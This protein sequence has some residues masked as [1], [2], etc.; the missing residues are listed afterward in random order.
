MSFDFLFTDYDYVDYNDELLS[1]N[2][3]V[4]TVA[5]ESV[6]DAEWLSMTSLAP[7]GD[8]GGGQA[9]PRSTNISSRSSTASGLT[10]TDDTLPEPQLSAVHDTATQLSAEMQAVHD[11]ATQKLR[12]LQEAATACRFALCDEFLPS[13]RNGTYTHETKVFICLTH[14]R[15]SFSKACTYALTSVHKAKSHA[16]VAAEA[17]STADVGGSHVKKRHR[18]AKACEACR[19]G[20]RRCERERGAASCTHCSARGVAC[21][22]S[23]GDGKD[24]DDD[25]DDEGD[26]DAVAAADEAVRTTSVAL[27]LDRATPAVMSEALLEEMGHSDDVASYASFKMPPGAPQLLLLPPRSLTTIVRR[28]H[29]SGGPT[30]VNMNDEFCTLTGMARSE[31]Q[32]SPVDVVLAPQ[33]A[34]SIVEMLAMLR[35]SMSLPLD[36]HIVKA[37]MQ[38]AISINGEWFPADL[39]STIVFRN[40]LPSLAHFCIDRVLVEQP[41]HDFSPASI[42]MSPVLNEELLRHKDFVVNLLRASQSN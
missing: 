12:T 19:I 41:L 4:P 30:V 27:P 2:A 25:D 40:R 16:K 23:G 22:W 18:A 8:G 17:M 29:M 33:S 37:S 42:G 36:R 15:A 6:F 7:V 35:R 13:L 20:K 31:L 39:T 9:S 32:F 11:T 21:E 28:N 38:M 5:T 3:V 14:A 26:R 24:R 10:L 34:S 1:F